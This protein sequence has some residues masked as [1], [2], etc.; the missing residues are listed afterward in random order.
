MKTF[1]K[2]IFLGI[3]FFSIFS[4]IQS[5]SA[6]AIDMG[7]KCPPGGCLTPPPIGEVA[8]EI[9]TDKSF[10]AAALQ[11]VN[12]FLGFL[13]L[14]AVIAVIYGGFLM[15]LSGGEDENVTKGK[16]I[17]LY[18]GLGIIII[19]LSYAIVNF[20]IDAGKD[21]PNTPPPV[22]NPDNPKDDKPVV[23]DKDGKLAEKNKDG[24]TT[25]IVINPTNP[26][27]PPGLILLPDNTIITKDGTKIP[28]KIVIKPDGSAALVGKDGKE[29]PP[30]T[31]IN[32]DGSITLPNGTRIF[33]DGTTILADGTI[34]L[35]DGT[36]LPPGSY[37]VLDDGTILLPNGT[38]ISSNFKT[39]DS[40][41]KILVKAIAEPSKGK[42]PLTLQLSGIDSKY[43]GLDETI[44]D[45]SF[46][47][48]YIDRSGKTIE[49][50]GGHSKIVTLEQSG[51]YVFTLRIDKRESGP[52]QMDGVDTVQVTVEDSGPPVDFLINGEKSQLFQEFSLSEAGRGIVFSP[53]LQESELQNVQE[54]SWDFGDGTPL[55]KKET[56]DPITHIFSKKGEYSVV[57]SVKD[58][59]G[60]TNMR[61]VTILVSDIVARMSISPRERIVGNPI[62]FSASASSSNLGDIV[63]YKWTLIDSTGEKQ[64]NSE[65]NFSKIFPKGGNVQVSLSITDS[66]GETAVSSEIITIETQKPTA[67]FDARPK[68]NSQPSLILFDAGL[69]ND[70]EGSPLTYS[71]DFENDGTYEITNLSS[72]RAEYTFSETGAHNIKLEVTD[73][74]GKSDATVKRIDISSV[75]N[76]EFTATTFVTHPEEQITFSAK[77]SNAIK[78]YWDFGDSE[79]AQGSQPDTTHIFRNKGKY[80]VELTVFDTNDTENSIQHSIY[81][82]EKDM[83]VAG[84]EVQKDGILQMIESD[85][86]GEGKPGIS[87]SRVD[88]VT[89]DA[90]PSINRDGSHSNLEYEWIF[91][92][93]TFERNKTANK[94]FNEPADK[95]DC[96][97]V[98][99]TVKDVLSQKTNTA[100]VLWIKVVNS[101]PQMDSLV[102]SIPENKTAPVIVP[103][104]VQNAK[105]PDGNVVEYKWWA[106]RSGEKEKIG[107]HTS[108]IPQTSIILPAYGNPKETSRYYFVVEMKDNLGKSINSEDLFGKSSFVEVVNGENRSPLVDFKMEKTSIDEGDTITFYATAKDPLGGTIPDSGYYWDFDGDN[109]YDD[110]SSGPQ[111]SHR[112]EKPGEY[113]VKLKVIYRGLATSQ[114]RTVYVARRHKLP[115]AAFSYTVQGHNVVFDAGE[116][117]ADGTVPNNRLTYSWDF[118]A[119]KD[120]D[121]DGNSENDV[122]STEMRTKEFFEDFGMRSVKLTVADILGVE[123]NVIRDV[124]VAESGRVLGKGDRISSSGEALGIFGSIRLKSSHSITT[125]D[126]VLGNRVVTKN[127]KTQLLAF[128]KNANNTLFEGQIQFRI[129]SGSATI[130]SESVT[131]A[132]GEAATQILSENTGK[133]V[134]EATAKN[135]VSGDI[136]EIIT[137][138]VE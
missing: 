26:R 87:V 10:R 59:L 128:V 132:L 21:Q 9:I 124:P 17:I 127:E 72:S 1:F 126:L 79:I 119:K 88:V 123:D 24:T 65:E 53:R 94:K 136:S 66:S 62:S 48:S 30:G 121:G 98:K 19:L 43:P 39:P 105:D 118:D 117:E 116:S 15:L 103:L 12:Y 84:Y 57:L 85:H 60:Q 76:V 56:G 80:T 37:N 35:P 90:E 104:K 113:T 110:I 74:S 107:L 33:P 134:I 99:L 47:W 51:R 3:F 125:L 14:V 42:A 137:L 106:Y 46:H 93:R 122:D 115:K 129:L 82:G 69:S 131:A 40:S 95:T 6:S 52:E 54:Y 92:D 78:Y 109:I 41:L 20:F 34:I 77:S 111:A 101:A 73:D 108:T 130:S 44:P 83:P 64:E 25:P 49:L 97:P 100:E 31:I 13:G 89:F 135:T 50:G 29:L 16:K 55:R 120:S 38:Q 61:T 138:L 11:V 18:A 96:F 68:S 5:F 114:T 86:C 27:L 133:V 71:W 36:I 102:V 63:S 32:A 70:P 7:Q 8:P 45:N 112:Y 22:E 2:Y 4:G 67:G 28:G 58:A 91:H 23:V 75:L 81:V